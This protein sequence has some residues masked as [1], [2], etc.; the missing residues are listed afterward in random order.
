MAIFAGLDVGDKATHLCV[1]GDAGA[2]LWRGVGATDPEVLADMLRRHAPGLTRVVLETGSLSAFLY[3]GLAERGVPV[4]CVCVRHAKGVLSVR[5][6]K[7][8]P[9]HVNDP[10]HDPPVIHPRY[11]VRQREIRLDPAHLRL[12]QQPRLGHQQRLLDTAIESSHQRP[13]KQLM[14][15]KPN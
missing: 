8:A 3:H 2:V 5:A 4:V 6:N 1:I 14:G 12:A 13:R 10:R 9:D 11:P 7:P 15:P